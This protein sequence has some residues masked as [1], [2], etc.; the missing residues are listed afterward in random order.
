MATVNS[1]Q[2]GTVTPGGASFVDVSLGTS[3]VTTKSIIFIS[4]RGTNNAPTNFQFAGHFIDGDTLRIERDG[5]ASGM[6]V[7]W[8]VV[9][10]QSGVYVHHLSQLEPDPGTEID[11]TPES[12]SLSE[13][14]C[15]GNYVTAG[16]TMG[17]DDFRKISIVENQASIPATYH[18]LVESGQPASTGSMLYVQV[19]EYE[20]ATVQRLPISL[21]VNDFT[22]IISHNRV[23]LTNSVPIIS[24][25]LDPSSK[26]RV[27]QYMLSAAQETTASVVVRRLDDGCAV[28]GELQVVSFGDDTETTRILVNQN[29]STTLSQPINNISTPDPAATIGISGGYGCYGGLS[30]YSADDNMGSTWFTIKTIN[31]ATQ[32]EVERD[33]SDGVAAE[34]DLYGIEFPIGEQSLDVDCNAIAD[35]GTLAVDVNAPVSTESAAVASSEA[36]ATGGS[37]GDTTGFTY[38]YP[39]GNPYPDPPPKG[40]GT[41]YYVAPSVEGG[42]SNGNDGLTPGSAFGDLQF[43]VDQ[44][45]P[46]DT[47]RLLGG[48]YIKNKTQNDIGGWAEIHN[49]NE[50][51]E[52]EPLWIEN[53][54][55]ESVFYSGPGLS[56][57]YGIRI[58]GYTKHVHIKG[59]HFLGYTN[60]VGDPGGQQRAHIRFQGNPD[61]D[62]EYPYAHPSFCQVWNCYAE[63][64]GNDNLNGMYSVIGSYQIRFINCIAQGDDFVGNPTTL[65][66]PQGFEFYSGSVFPVLYDNPSGGLYSI[67]NDQWDTWAGLGTN[68]LD[69][70]GQGYPVFDRPT[71]CE[72]INCISA[73]H[74]WGPDDSNCMLI[75]G[76]TDCK[77]I[78][79]IFTNSG[80]DNIDMQH[81]VRSEIAHSIWYRADQGVNNNGIRSANKGGMMI[82][83]HHNIVFNHRIDSSDMNNNGASKIYH[84]IFV[85]GEQY[86]FDVLA[87]ENTGT[88][89]KWIFANNVVQG[90]PANSL[91]RLGLSNSVLDYYG[92]NCL[93][94][95]GSGDGINVDATPSPANI[96]DDPEFEIGDTF[97]PDMNYPYTDVDSIAN[98]VE[99]IRSQFVNAFRPS[100]T[101]PLRDAGMILPGLNDNFTG[102]A[103]DIGPIPYSDAQVPTFINVTIDAVANAS[104]EADGGTQPTVATALALTEASG[105][106][107]EPG[108]EEVS[109]DARAQASTMAP[110][111]IDV[112]AVVSAEAV[113][114]DMDLVVY[115]ASVSAETGAE[116]STEAT[117]LV[118]EKLGD[119][120][121]AASGASQADDQ[122]SFLVTANAQA[123]AS[124]VVNEGVLFVYFV[125]ADARAAGFT[126]A[127]ASAVFSVTAEAAA[128]AEAE[129]TRAQLGDANAQALAVTFA[130]AEGGTLVEE[131]PP[132]GSCTLNSCALTSVSSV[133]SYLNIGNDDIIESAFEVWQDGTLGTTGAN[134]EVTDELVRC[135]RTDGAGDLAQDYPFST[136][137]TLVELTSAINSS[138]FGWHAVLS[139]IEEAASSS[140]VEEG[141]VSAFGFAGRA[142]AKYLN[143]CKIIQLINAATE[144]IH[145][146]CGR[147]FCATDHVEEV[148]ATRSITIQHWP[149]INVRSVHAGRQDIISVNCLDTREPAD[150]AGEAFVEVSTD[151]AEVHPDHQRRDQRRHRRGQLPRRQQQRPVDAADRGRDQRP[152]R[153]GLGGQPD[154]E[155]PRQPAVHVHDEQ[156]RRPVPQRTEALGDAWRS[157]LRLPHGLR[158]G[159]PHPAEERGRRVLVLRSPVQLATHWHDGANG[160]LV[161]HR[162]ADHHRLPGRIRGHPGGYRG[163]RQHG[164]LRK[165]HELR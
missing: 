14:F 132:V 48:H 22:Q 160:S 62:S 41:T 104:S 55:G 127:Q 165:H 9:E 82:S 158:E 162:R 15:I 115:R 105:I 148:G 156:R 99:Y 8:K 106:V 163:A 109:C 56:Q 12:L 129:P 107:V 159:H 117:T 164:D 139:G 6:T 53:E 102:T 66:G 49:R 25:Y 23:T 72:V 135:A 19:V 28:D 112:L 149:L 30:T 154:P 121:A 42:G 18:V 32:F 90:A 85:G 79:S 145:R 100:S 146:Y 133:K 123:V 26:D 126:G 136:Y 77:V 24:Y 31:S 45:G 69:Y 89:N 137:P 134:I 130:F 29:S 138:G 63:E 122:V 113:A 150:R 37:T 46:G 140:L 91:L 1:I 151:P 87:D 43:A 83:V 35:A 70:N 116:G 76:G 7:E 144:K 98:A 67:P 108:I 52:S 27:G 103:P 92:A 34:L 80:D 157:H 81:N 16:S 5:S 114:S 64:L 147:V 17:E 33:A 60:G 155:R 71:Q 61:N 47:I 51:T 88:V 58:R 110:V 39:S 57:R 120:D 3:V 141:T 111:N 84:N 13:M 10:F 54:P 44:A 50:F 131:S 101:S 38:I 152:R 93:H 75:R 97:V 118:S 11:F 143:E 119:S 4:V 161:G 94:D 142:T 95:K 86:G 78:N 153:Q 2:R 21:G 125:D 40:T 59:I 36:T 20:G 68:T 124:D 128:V 65:D 73:D 96:L 74:V